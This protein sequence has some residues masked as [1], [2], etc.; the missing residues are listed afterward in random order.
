MS[1]KIYFEHLFV[2][3]MKTENIIHKKYVLL[4]RNL[5]VLMNLVILK[6]LVGIKI[7]KLILHK[8]S[9]LRNKLVRYHL[10][11]LNSINKTQRLLIYYILILNIK[12]L[13]LLGKVLWGLNLNI[14]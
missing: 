2:S 4:L 6:T 11:L 5:W 10:W 1:Q 3:K 8:R 9:L 12:N 7:N 14:L 13:K